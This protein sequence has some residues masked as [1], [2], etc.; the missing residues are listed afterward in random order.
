MR[1]GWADFKM[2]LGWAD[3]KMRLGWDRFKGWPDFAGISGSGWS[4]WD[5]QKYV[6]FQVRSKHTSTVFC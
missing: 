6:L 5:G 4:G 1:L 3:F 2:R